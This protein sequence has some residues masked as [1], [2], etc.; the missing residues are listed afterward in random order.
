MCTTLKWVCLG[1]ALFTWTTPARADVVG[2]SGVF[3]PNQWTLTSE[4]LGYADVTGAPAT[5]ALIGGDDDSGV[6]SITRYSIKMPF[7]ALINFSW[8]YSTTDYMGPDLDRA[9]YS[10]GGVDSQLT[11]NYG[12]DIQSGSVS[13]LNLSQGEILGFYVQ[14]MDSMFGPATIT[15]GEFRATSLEPSSLALTPT[16]EPSTVLLTATAAIG[17]AATRVIRRKGSAKNPIRQS[18]AFSSGTAAP[19]NQS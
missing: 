17:F 1:L 14:S 15:I 10:V 4:A 7:A 19:Y 11:I 12:L 5:L 3:S 18:P 13:G 8:N 16:P 9:G 2:F 6:V